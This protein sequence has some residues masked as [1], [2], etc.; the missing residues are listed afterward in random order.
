MPDDVWDFD[1]DAP[2]GCKFC[3]WA[4]SGVL[5]APRVTGNSGERRRWH[6]TQHPERLMERIL[7]SSGGPVL[8][9]F[10]GTGTTLRVAKRLGLDCDIVELDAGYCAAIAMETDS[11]ITILE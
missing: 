9:L 10:G 3:G 7:L 6:P 4:A 8:D 5:D 11:E 2:D 1:A